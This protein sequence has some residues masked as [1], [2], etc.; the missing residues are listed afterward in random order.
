MCDF[1]IVKLP[2]EQHIHANLHLPMNIGAFYNI[3]LTKKLSLYY[4]SGV[5]NLSMDPWEFD[6]GKVWNICTFLSCFPFLNYCLHVGLANC[7][8]ESA[9]RGIVN[10][11]KIVKRDRLMDN[12]PHKFD[13]LKNTFQIM[14]VFVLVTSLQC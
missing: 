10:I 9:I 4:W 2:H 5:W 3:S 7:R 6:Q 1:P 12:F 13:R 8:C 14:E 11:I